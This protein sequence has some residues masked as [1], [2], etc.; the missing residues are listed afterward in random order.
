[1]RKNIEDEP[2]HKLGF[3]M[4]NKVDKFLVQQ[5]KKNEK[6]HN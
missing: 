4:I 1:M 3:E 6:R 5:I 2:S